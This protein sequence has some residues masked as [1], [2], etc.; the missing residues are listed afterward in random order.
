MDENDRQFKFQYPQIKF[1]Q[2][3]LKPIHS[4]V[5]CGSLLVTT[6]Q[7]ASE[8][9]EKLITVWPFAEEFASLPSRHEKYCSGHL[10]CSR[11]FSPHAA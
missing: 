8:T 11:I 9:V 7:V 10:E 1:Y 2:D 5:V 3:K 6:G 4:S